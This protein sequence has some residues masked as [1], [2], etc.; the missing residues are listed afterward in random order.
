MNSSA[1]TITFASPNGLCPTKKTANMIVVNVQSCM[2]LHQSLNSHR[3]EFIAWM[4]V[5]QHHHVIFKLSA[6][7]YILYACRDR[8]LSTHATHLDQSQLVSSLKQILSSFSGTSRQLRQVTS[9]HQDTAVLTP[10][11]GFMLRTRN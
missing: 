10:V 4:F 3:L 5:G 6:G 8:V 7:T 1:A 11:S 2:K 9:L